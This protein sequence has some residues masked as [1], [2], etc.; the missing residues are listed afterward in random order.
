MLLIPAQCECEIGTASEINREIRNYYTV[1]KS[2]KFYGK[3]KSL[4]ADMQAQSQEAQNSISVIK[5]D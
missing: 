1:S 2:L 4:H 3:R 5:Y